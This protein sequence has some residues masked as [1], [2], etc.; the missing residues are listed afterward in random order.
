MQIVRE[1]IVGFKWEEDALGRSKSSFRGTHESM[2]KNLENLST[3]KIME[4]MTGKDERYVQSSY[5]I[6]SP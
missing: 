1:I 2:L 5:H 3:E 6:F 4:A